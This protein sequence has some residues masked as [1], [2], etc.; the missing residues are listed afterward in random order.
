MSCY[1]HAIA[2]GKWTFQLFC[3]ELLKAVILGNDKVSYIVMNSS[4][5]SR[6]S[7]IRIVELCFKLFL[8]FDLTLLGSQTM[9]NY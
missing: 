5:G 2:G 7:L 1:V 9:Y 6:C 4:L 8:T 3:N